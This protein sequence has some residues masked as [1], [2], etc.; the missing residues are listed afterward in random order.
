[1]LQQDLQTTQNN[2]FHQKAGQ[3]KLNPQHESVPNIVLVLR[4][5][6]CIMM[7]PVRKPKYKLN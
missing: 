6:I 1:M 4:M 2:D 7:Y 3:T 5:N